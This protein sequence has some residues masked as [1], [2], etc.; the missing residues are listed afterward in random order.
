MHPLKVAASSCLMISLSA[1]SN[2]ASFPKWEEPTVEI[3][4]QSS[5][6]HRKPGFCKR[7][8]CDNHRLFF[9]PSRPET[10][11]TQM[12]RGW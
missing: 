2:V 9:D 4:R 6:P 12:H 11:A 10:K 5:L 7:K 8:G 1:C 3:T